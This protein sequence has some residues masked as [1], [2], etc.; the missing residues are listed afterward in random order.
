MSRRGWGALLAFV[1]PLLAYLLTLEPTVYWFDSGVYVTAAATGGVAHPTGFPS[2]LLA[3]RLATWLPLGTEAWR[4]NL[5]SAL[6]GAAASYFL[7]RLLTLLLDP[8]KGHA[9]AA[10]GG[11]WTLAFGYEFWSQAINA[12]SFVFTVAC[13]LGTWWALVSLIQKPEKPAARLLAAAGALTLALGAHPSV[14]VFLPFLAVLLWRHRS[15]L[16]SN[17]RATGGAA[18][19]VVIG[20]F[21]LYLTIPLRSRA[22]PWMDWG[23]PRTLEAAFVHIFGTE[24]GPNPQRPYSFSVIRLAQVLYASLRL[25]AIQST[26]AL[27]F[28]VLGIVHLARHRKWLLGAVALIVV[29]D[30]VATSTYETGNREAWFLPLQVALALSAGFGW[31]WLLA[32]IS[33]KEQPLPVFLSAGPLLAGIL[34]AVPAAIWGL[35]IDRHADVF[36][37]D[38]E[39]N[40]QRSVEP[41]ALILDKGDVLSALVSYCGTNYYQQVRHEAPGIRHVGLNMLYMADW[42][43]EHLRKHTDLVIPESVEQ[44]A[45]N[46]EPAVMARAMRD[47]IDAN[48]AKRPVY[49]MPEVEQIADLSGLSLLPSGLVLKVLRKPGEEADLSRWNFSF[50]DPYLPVRVADPD[51]N[52]IRH[53]THPPPQPFTLEFNYGESWRGLCFYYGL[54]YLR[55]SEVLRAK[56][57]VD[58]ARLALAKAARFAEDQP[59]LFTRLADS[60]QRAG[61][62]ERAIWLAQRAVKASPESPGAHLI[63]ATL[64]RD[65]GDW[66]AGAD[67]FDRIVKS[68]EAKG[69][70]QRFPS[71]SDQALYGLAARELA[72]LVLPHGAFQPALAYYQR[73][74]AVSSKPDPLL[75]SHFGL[76]CAQLGDRVN[77]LRAFGDAVKLDPKD[78]TLRINLG[79]ALRDSRKGDEAKKEWE[80]AIRLDLTKDKALAKR[81][82]DLLRERPTPPPAGEAEGQS[83]APAPPPGLAL[84]P[85]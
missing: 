68:F 70:P 35:R 16:T 40:L 53:A 23:S 58:E 36:P 77:A 22:N 85:R 27:P 18:A 73:A 49:L 6:S 67:E 30:W 15:I 14:V 24:S 50:H 66:Q 12:E 48:L 34:V 69:A 42:Y 39:A 3:G 72:E 41:N 52:L 71:E 4:L 63:L 5:L 65:T 55:L 80:E 25:Y 44:S 32:K 7:Y 29:T 20:T 2:F 26:L 19:L 84:P 46:P 51:P 59:E 21:L 43:R 78:P 60:A 8:G 81:A 83:L 28:V 79:L 1:G 37:D 62:K 74:L 33:S 10:V 57:R 61:E 76:A 31:R 75:L 54:A 45:G 17:P 11:A 56:G 82:R 9:L 47:F 13:V 64:Y 38:F